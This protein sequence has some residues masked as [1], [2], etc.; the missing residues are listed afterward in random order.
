MKRSRWFSV[1]MKRTA[2]LMLLGGSGISGVA[3]ELS[4]WDA[5]G[6]LTWKGALAPGIATVETAPSASGPWTPV[7][8]VFSLSSTGSVAL[9][10]ESATQFRRVRSDLMEPGAA[11]FRTL[12]GAYGLLETI[13]GN[14]AGQEDPVSYWSEFYEG[15]PGS[16]AA[17]S[18]PHYAMADRTGRVFIADKNSHSVLRVDLDGTIHTHAGSHE[19]GFEGEGPLA[20]TQMKLRFPNALWVR[21]DGTVYVLDTG[22]GRV[23]RVDLEGT[24][25]TLFVATSNGGE[26]EGGRTLWVNDTETLAYFGAETRVRSWTPSAGLRTVASGFSEI[27]NL[28]VEA[29]GNL[30]VADRGAHYVYRVTPAGVRSILAGNG[31]TSGGGHGSPGRSTGLYGVRGVWPM[32]TGGFLLLTHD[33]CQLWYLDAG[34]T[35]WRLL[36]GDGGRTHAGDGLPFYSAEPRISEGRSVTLDPQGNILVCESDWGYVR[37]I[38]FERLPD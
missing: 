16:W 9:A 31:K 35:I 22:N 15:V 33:G 17:L 14:G 1:V 10:R 34:G 24:M 13:A 28:C 27:G 23:R 25:Q 2:A 12:V 6:A 8:N 30:I 3:V 38:R 32:P 18:R 4:G 7:R 29:N 5:E 36:N 19:G 11:G 26:L 37:R 21:G 20:A